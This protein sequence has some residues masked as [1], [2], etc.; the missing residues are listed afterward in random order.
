MKKVKECDS[1][2]EEREKGWHDGF[3]A[4]YNRGLIDFK[5]LLDKRREKTLKWVNEDRKKLGL[6]KIS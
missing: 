2:S 3:K 5:K 4:G 6:K 1:W